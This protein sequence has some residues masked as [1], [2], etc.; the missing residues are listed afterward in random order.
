MLRHW[1]SRMTSELVAVEM[2]V[3][4]GTSLVPTAGRRRTESGHIRNDG[5]ALARRVGLRHEA[6]IRPHKHAERN[7]QA[8]VFGARTTELV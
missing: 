8:S 2:A 6:A 4:S 5:I 3:G 7:G 1:P